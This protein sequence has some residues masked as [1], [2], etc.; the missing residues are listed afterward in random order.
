MLYEIS[1]NEYML[2]QALP[3]NYQN[4]LPTIE[5]L[6]NQLNTYQQ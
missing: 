6:E 4:Q 5:Q 1:I 3:E 2:T